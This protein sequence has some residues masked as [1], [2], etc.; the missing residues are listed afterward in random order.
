MHFFPLKD[1]RSLLFCKFPSESLNLSRS[2]LK[3]FIIFTYYLIFFL[4]DFYLFSGILEFW[5]LVTVTF[6]FTVLY[7]NIYIKK[8]PANSTSCSFKQTF[9]LVFYIL[10]SL[11]ND[12]LI[13]TYFCI[14]LMSA[15]LEWA[16]L[17][18]D[19]KSKEHPGAHSDNYCIWKV[20]F[21][22]CFLNFTS[23]ELLLFANDSLKSLRSII[24]F[25]CFSFSFW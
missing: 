20:T 18:K 4:F 25:E 5:C 11:K 17:L 21:F 6:K 14:F 12:T 10:F 16:P 1:L 3:C 22:H 15:P 19:R 2:F 24:L 8:Y 13:N 9:Y 23:E 7:N